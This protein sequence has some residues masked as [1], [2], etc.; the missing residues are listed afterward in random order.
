M[1]TRYPTFNANKVKSEI[2][3]I[4]SGANYFDLYFTI[5]YFILQYNT[6]SSNLFLASDIFQYAFG[7]GESIP[8]VRIDVISDGDERH[9]EQS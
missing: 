1:H 6:F 9:K 5:L 3:V 2:S 7:D 8:I 4:S